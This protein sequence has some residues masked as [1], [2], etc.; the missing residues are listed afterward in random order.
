MQV[1]LGSL[2]N[3]NNKL[4]TLLESGR[5][6]DALPL[7]LNWL[8]Y[9]TCCRVRSKLIYAVPPVLSPNFDMVYIASGK[10]ERF[11]ATGLSSTTKI[12][13]WG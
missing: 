8:E 5:L 10:G 1:A 2:K 3:S 6:N 4:D 11:R 7:G 13:P 9:P 12:R